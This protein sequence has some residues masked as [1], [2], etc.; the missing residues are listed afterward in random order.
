MG[1]SRHGLGYECTA[2]STR[3]GNR[4]DVACVCTKGLPMPKL[5]PSIVP[6]IKSVL[7]NFAG[8]S[9][10]PMAEGLCPCVTRSLTIFENVPRGI[11]RS[12][13]SQ[14]ATLLYAASLRLS[15]SATS[16]QCSQ[17]RRD[18]SR[19]RSQGLCRYKGRRKADV[20]VKNAGELTSVFKCS[21]T[22]ASSSLMNQ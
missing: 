3:A 21:G 7:K 11:S 20:L 12:S 14:Y 16:Q 1:D 4:L 10:N 18:H 22:Q 6:S 2:R 15:S 17:C 5:P 8:F 13:R 9:F 19:T